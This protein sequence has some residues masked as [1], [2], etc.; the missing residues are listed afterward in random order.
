[1]FLYSVMT[2][3]QSWL[4]T[5]ILLLSAAYGVA[6]IGV[7][8]QIAFRERSL[9]ALLIPITFLLLHVF[10]GVG[11]LSAIV[12]NARSPSSKFGRPYETAEPF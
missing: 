12:S 11:T 10:Y 2:H 9:E 3:T 1:M 5:P 7:S 8:C 6:S 4:L